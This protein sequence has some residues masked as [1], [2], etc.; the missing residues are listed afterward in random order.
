M[1]CCDKSNLLYVLS[2][3]FETAGGIEKNQRK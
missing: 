2:D 1:M 3:K